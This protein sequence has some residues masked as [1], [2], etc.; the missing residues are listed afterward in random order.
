MAL[1]M[2][3]AL[4][5]SASTTLESI[6]LPIVL[7]SACTYRLSRVGQPLM[8]VDQLRVFE[9]SG[10]LLNVSGSPA[11]GSLDQCIVHVVASSNPSG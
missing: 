3:K 11:S 7:V 2:C 10:Q 4:F 6:A 9:R 8:Y 5:K 1:I